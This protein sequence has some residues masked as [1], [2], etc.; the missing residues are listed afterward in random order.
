MGSRRA[1]GMAGGILAG[2]VAVFTA[3][4]AWAAPAA[5]AAPN[6]A[7]YWRVDASTHLKTLNRDVQV[8]RGYFDGSIDLGT[9]DLSGSLDLPPATTRIDLAGL[10]PIVDATFAM[11]QVQ[12][13]T[14]HVDLST[15]HVTSTAVFDIRVLSVKP[16]GTD[17]NLVGDD[18]RT[19]EPISVTM[20]GT[21][22]LVNGSTFT[23][24]Y[25]IPPLEN[26]EL[27]TAALNLVIPG[28]GNTFTGTFTPPPPS[29]ANAGTDLNVESGATFQ[30][31]GSGS[32]DPE[33]RPFT[34]L[35]TQIAGPPATLTDEQTAHPT[36]KAPT[37]PATLKFRLTV[38]NSERATST[39]DVVVTVAPK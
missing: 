11:T 29:I 22:D 4:A 21:A 39:D 34:Y 31:D 18:C 37:G 23:G 36:V 25:S 15:L 28:D 32:S 26:C 16:L 20:A 35:W 17:V 33:G 2:L 27:I 30:L 19:S 5:L 13:I 3:A 1:R 10:L 38:T 9:G 6:L 14:G 24:T 8:P 12:P 7:V